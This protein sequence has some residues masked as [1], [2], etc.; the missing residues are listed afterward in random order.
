M[1]ATLTRF[2]AALTTL[3]AVT[4]VTLS[5]QGFTNPSDAAGC[6]RQYS[7]SLYLVASGGYYWYTPTT[8]TVGTGCT[9]ID[10]TPT[11][12]KNSSGCSQFR[13]RNFTTGTT[14]NYVPICVGHTATFFPSSGSGTSYRV[15]AQDESTVTV[16]D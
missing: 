11:V 10:V 13:I 14:S 9:Y 8:H 3:P 2:V 1:R 5:A 4:I 7:V 6:T 15:E 12:I 16:L